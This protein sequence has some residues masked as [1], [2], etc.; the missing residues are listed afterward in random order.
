V[1][2]SPH[3]DDLTA[4]GTCAILNTYQQRFKELQMTSEKDYIMDLLRGATTS[5]L[6][7]HYDLAKHKVIRCKK[8]LKRLDK[9]RILNNNNVSRG[10]YNFY[11]QELCLAEK[12]KSAI[13][14]LLL[15]V[16]NKHCQINDK[17]SGASNI[18]EIKKSGFDIKITVV[19]KQQAAE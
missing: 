15:S 12:E 6:L 1:A 4:I 8:N 7:D 13:L 16:Y 10:S 11:R 3:P 2:K 9:A 18:T 5:S 17:S 19:K 14:G